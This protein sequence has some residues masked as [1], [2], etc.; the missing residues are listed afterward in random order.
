[1]PWRTST[2]TFPPPC[3]Q[4]PA[5]KNPKLLSGVPLLLPGIASGSPEDYAKHAPELVFGL[6][7][8][9]LHLLTNHIPIF[10]TFSGL[11]VLVIA[12]WKK[13]HLARQI[14]LLLLFLG[15][16]GAILTYWLGQQSYKAVRSLAD[17]AGQGWL[18]LHM[19]RAEQVVWVFWLA[20]AIIAGA[21][22]W[23]WRGRRHTVLATVLAGLLGGISLGLSG[24]IADVG[25]KIRHPEL[26]GLE[27]PPAD[28]GEDVPHTH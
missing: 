10:V 19:E 5:M 28:T 16:G 6:D 8:P 25:G 12:L 9:H 15:S 27:Q 2:R 1:M 13:D 26:R 20:F 22:A 24:W 23:C 4:L 17:E 7:A 14:A 21:L 11:V 3:F 18:D